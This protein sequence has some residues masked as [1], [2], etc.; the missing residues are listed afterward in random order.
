L[1]SPLPVDPSSSAE[2]SLKNDSKKQLPATTGND[3][4]IAKT[5]KTKI[6]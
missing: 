2:R 3:N 4:M 6:I 5:Q 1:L